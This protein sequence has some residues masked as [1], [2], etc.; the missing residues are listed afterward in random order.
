[1]ARTAATV[2]ALAGLDSVAAR[3]ACAR[4]R[5]FLLKQQ[6]HG[7]RCAKTPEPRLV[8]GAFPQTPVHDFLQIDVTGH[9]LLALS[10]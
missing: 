3:A 6:I 8:H 2:E 7:D 4:A 1:V 9:A 5:A 10:A